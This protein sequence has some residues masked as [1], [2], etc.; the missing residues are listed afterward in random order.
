[1][2]GEY[3]P[4]L[5][6]RC[7]S[8]VLL[9]GL[10]GLSAA[11]VSCTPEEP[12]IQV[13]LNAVPAAYNDLL[14]V[15]PSDFT[16]DVAFPDPARVDPDSLRVLVN[17]FG[18]VPI[19]VTP[20]RVVQS[21]AGAVF[22]IPP[23]AALPVGSHWVVAIV[24]GTD[25]GVHYT[26]LSFAVRPHPATGPPLA[27]PQVV[28][29]DLEADPDGDGIADFEGD[30]ASFGL[31]PGAGSGLEAVMWDWATAEILA[32]LRA[33]FDTP[34]PSGLPGGDAAAIS[35][36][37]LPPGTGPYTHLCVGGEDPTGG[38]VAG[39]TLFDAGNA[40][41]ADVACDT[42]TPTGVFPR[43]LHGYGGSATFQSA[44]LPTQQTP[45][46]SHAL[47]PIVLGPGFDPGDPAQWAR[48]EEIR[49][50]VET[51]AQAVATLT[52]HETGHLI[53]LVPKGAPGR[54][55]FGGS[56]GSAD[57]HNLM[58]SGQVPAANWVMNPGPS[59]TFD[60]LVGGGGKP[61]PRIRELNWAYLR[62]RIVLDPLVTG[63]Y[64]PPSLSYGAPGQYSLSG[65]PVVSCTVHGSGFIE[66]SQT[67]QLRLIG[68]LS[69]SLV[70]E[71][72]VSPEEVTGTLSVLQLA[73]GIYDLELVNGDGQK[74]V[75]TDAVEV[76]P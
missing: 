5:L 30:L 19:D 6:S 14:V 8:A 3:R 9:L 25:G 54:G 42:F 27:D 10:L 46:G 32:R 44:F 18:G 53:G 65:P 45:V 29:V 72:L 70:N 76:V 55:L 36:V 23:Q 34:N 41:P 63:I 62:G 61:L 38:S 64:P 12:L 68:P 24:D 71:V 28:F 13:T 49:T 7:C 66:A 20:H 48:F 39:N 17:P 50:A 47:D 15:P 52:A 35:F 1:M 43:E 73:P 40:N 60:E 21:A 4:L 37:D 74:A 22:R 31:W 59:F 16:I 33:F 67:P 51:L 2:S 56:G 26:A 69:L 75:L 58:P 57:A 11:Q